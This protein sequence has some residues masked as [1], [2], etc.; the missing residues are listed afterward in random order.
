MPLTETETAQAPEVEDEA[1]DEVK[2]GKEQPKDDG[3]FGV[4]L[5]AGYLEDDDSDEY[6]E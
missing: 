5:Q 6:I 2:E 1:G 3:K 4:L